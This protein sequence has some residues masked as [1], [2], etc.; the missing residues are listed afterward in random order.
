MAKHI[1]EDAFEAEVVKSDQL[2]MIDFYAEWCGPCKMLAPV[3]DSLTSEF[4]G[5]AK[6]FKCDVDKEPVLAGQFGVQSIPT[7]VFMKNGEVVD[8]AVGFQSKEALAEKLNT[9]A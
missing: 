1:T 3:I 9:L 8:K 4:D 2:V 5:K 7:I 6:I